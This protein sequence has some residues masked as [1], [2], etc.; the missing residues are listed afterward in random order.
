MST[1]STRVIPRA[2]DALR[3]QSS[4]TL[5]GRGSEDLWF[6]NSPIEKKTRLIGNASA[7]VGK[8]V[9][10]ALP[11]FSV[12]SLSHVDA[13]TWRTRRL[14]PRTYDKGLVDG[15]M[16]L[17]IDGNRKMNKSKHSGHVGVHY[18]KPKKKWLAQ[19]MLQRKRIFLGRYDTIEEAIEARKAAEDKYFGKYRN[20]E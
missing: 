19:I 3:M 6:R 2:V 4:M 16:L 13:E 7:T 8:S 18:D 20:K 14:L 17:A 10:S 15:T 1:N 11:I 9:L 5:Q 12:D